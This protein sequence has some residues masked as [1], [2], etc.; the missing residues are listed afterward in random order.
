MRSDW[1]HYERADPI[2]IDESVR[3]ALPPLR[4]HLGKNLVWRT[5]G[6]VDGTV[7]LFAL[8]K[9]SETELLKQRVPVDP[10]WLQLS[11]S[12]ACRTPSFQVDHALQLAGSEEVALRRVA[13]DDALERLYDRHWRGRRALQCGDRWRRKAVHADSMQRLDDEDASAQIQ[14]VS[15]WRDKAITTFLEQDPAQDRGVIS[16]GD[17]ASAAV[18]TGAVKYGR[19]AGSR[20]ARYAEAM[21]DPAMDPWPRWAARAL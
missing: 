5:Q 6:L 10:R 21:A 2:C 11:Q 7:C 19:R 4:T 14:D 13:H 15:R 16:I 1:R 18:A 9:L 3:R 8:V 20:R 12:K 17:A